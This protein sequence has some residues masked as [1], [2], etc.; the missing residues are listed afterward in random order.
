MRV[1]VTILLVLLLTLPAIAQAPAPPAP[2]PLGLA[3]AIAMALQQNQQ[4][5]VSAFEVAIAR[6]QLAQ[7][8]GA[9]APQINGQAS[10]T[11]TQ[12]AQATTIGFLAHGELHTIVIPPG[13]PNLYDA[14]VTLQYPLY[15]GGALE[16]QIALAEA[17][18]R[19]AE[20]TLERIKQQIVFAAR[21]AYFQLQLAQSG[22]E[23]TERSVAQANENLRVAR[24]RVAAGASP[25]FDEVQADVALATALQSRV[26]ARNAIAQSMQALAGVLNLPLTTPLRLTDAFTVR[27]VRETADALVARA[28]QA[29]PELAELAARQAA[30][31][32][33][34]ELAR[35]GARPNLALQASGAYSNTGG[36]FAGSSGSTSWSVTLAATLNLFDGG[37]TRE[38]VREA[39]LRLEQLRAIEA[40]QKQGV[41]LEVRQAYINLQSAAEELA[42]ADALIAQAQE[43][44]RIA[45]VRF[46]SGV[47]TNLE[48]LNAQTA[49]SQAE[50]GKVEALFNYNLARATLERAVGADLP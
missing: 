47:G 7:A 49:A 33:G 32:A 45:N 30:A 26:R 25:R 15:T 35:S 9:K 2:R 18:V 1:I 11:R 24:A 40:Q 10:V 27:P 20:A 16:A 22:L 28:V 12:E 43:A 23:V 21:Q 39:E 19:G 13:S 29:R 34:I 4:L 36:L 46:Q 6:A 3:E 41:E 8:R 44:L 48:V 37:V 14:R 50:A 17:N 42:G 5:R 31:Q 38:R